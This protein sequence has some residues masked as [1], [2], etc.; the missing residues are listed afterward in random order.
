[1][2]FN[3][4]QRNKMIA[5]LVAD[6]DWG[7]TYD[8]WVAIKEGRID[9]TTPEELMVWVIIHTDRFLTT[10]NESTIYTSGNNIRI[11]LCDSNEPYLELYIEKMAKLKEREL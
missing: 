1:M 9:H 5:T 3:I 10:A 7:E 11:E 4:D 8:K 2:R 6:I